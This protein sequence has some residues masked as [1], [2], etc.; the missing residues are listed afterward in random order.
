MAAAPAHDEGSQRARALGLLLVAGAALAAYANSLDVPLQFDDLWQLADNPRVHAPELGLA[1]L[2]RAAEEFPLHRW[3]AFVTFA[4]NHALHGLRP[5]GYHL[6]NVGVHAVNAVLVVALARRILAALGA[7]DPKGRDQAAIAA[8]L[9]FAV[10]PVQT[11]AVTYV[12]QR[13]TSLGTLFALLALLAWLEARGREGRARLA[14]V[15]ASALAAFLAFSCKENFAVLPA[16]VLL[17]EWVLDP[18]LGRKLAERW[19]PL[20]AA[21][22]VLGGAAIAV[23]WRYLPLL[24][25]EAAALGIPV[26]QRL[27]S[28][29]RVLVHYLSLLALPLPGRLHVDYAFQVSTGLLSPPAT[30]LGLAAVA[31]LAVLAV[32]TVR[33]APLVSL[34]VGWFLVALAIEQSALPIDLVFEHRLYFA[35]VG[36]FVLAGWAAVRFVRVPRIGAWAAVAPAAALLG[37]ATV[38]RNVTWHDPIALYSDPESVSPRFA[39]PL[40][41]VGVRLL[42]ERRYDEAGRVFRRAIELDPGNPAPYVDLGNIALDHERWDEAEGWYR[43]ALARARPD[44][45][46]QYNLGFALRRQ[47]RREEAARAYEDALRLSPILT[48]ARVELATLRDEAGDLAGALSGLDEAIRIDAGSALALENRALVRARLGRHAEALED[49]R[50]AER[51]SDGDAAALGVLAKVHQAAGRTAEATA[52]AEAALRKDPRNGEALEVLGRR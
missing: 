14:L 4:A 47:G 31:A 42:E 39:R 10:H 32:S 44:A 21:G 12:V 51:L 6:V 1:H 30:A 25:S 26:S 16:M 37:A 7:L 23:L 36:F 49:A 33:R 17:L 27:L 22:A 41:A 3:L 9:L 11:M 46:V 15:A 50:R 48:D 13:M 43:T 2:L 52:A 45:Q 34:A 24:R 5:L 40:L 19:R 38:A 18:A 8:G 28:Q 29:G 20:A 35:G